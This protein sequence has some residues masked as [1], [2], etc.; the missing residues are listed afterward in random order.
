MYY[1]IMY[2]YIKQY[3][4]RPR[5]PAEAGASYSNQTLPSQA[6]ATPLSFSMK[7]SDIQT[8]PINS[9]KF[10]NKMPTES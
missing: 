4:C 2:V 8:D 9:S 1:I 7:S 6:C 10:L 3:F 5:T